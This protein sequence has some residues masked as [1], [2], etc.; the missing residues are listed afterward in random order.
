MAKVFVRR[1]EQD[2]DD[3]VLLHVDAAH[4]VSEVMQDARGLLWTTEGAPALGDMQLCLDSDGSTLRNRAVFT[5]LGIDCTAATLVLKGR[6]SSVAPQTQTPPP[7]P[8][9]SMSPS[10][11]GTTST[12]GIANN[13]D[14]YGGGAGISVAVLASGE[15]TH[16][17][18]SPQGRRAVQTH[19]RSTDSSLISV[20]LPPQQRSGTRRDDG[21]TLLTGD[22]HSPR[23]P[24]RYKR[25]HSASPP[26]MKTTRQEWWGH[27]GGYGFG[28]AHGESAERAAP[29]KR[30]C[31]ETPHA[32]KAEH[33]STSANE[34]VT[35]QG[36]SNTPCRL[37]SPQS[38]TEGS[39]SGKRH[40]RAQEHHLD[41]TLQADPGT[42]R[43]DG[44]RLTTSTPREDPRAGGYGLGP[45]LRAKMTQSNVV[46][47]EV[48]LPAS[49]PPHNSK[50]FVSSVGAL[51]GQPSTTTAE[52]MP[53][54]RPPAPSPDTHAAR[55]APA[56]TPKTASELRRLLLQQVALC[57]GHGS[58][59]EMQYAWRQLCQGRG[60]LRVEDFCG[61]VARE[62]RVNVKVE[63]L[64]E[65]GHDAAR[66][67]FK[68]FC[69][70]CG[71][72][73]GAGEG[74]V[75]MPSEEPR[76]SGIKCHSIAQHT[77]RAPFGIVSDAPPPHRSLRRSQAGGASY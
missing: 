34:V 37:P 59:G 22:V 9:P 43:I 25:V 69:A 53:R 33:L 47:G 8:R 35:R 36:H 60:T 23:D 38:P 73:G 72:G 65:M 28:V 10:P 31:V 3:A 49:P 45:G 5:T 6:A 77:L 74:D 1:E 27:S 52:S 44:R 71:G 75:R 2:N 12:A 4:T 32:S 17:E 64:E 30:G 76:H 62:F 57:G 26:H 40:V 54:K 14:H 16:A 66:V 50:T 13:L 61:A 15:G 63:D 19:T 67:S 51:M 11:R 41:S 24:Q 56:V 29:V 20:G 48:D 70:L 21:L 18:H 42:M 68:D 46:L 39:P 7:L 58:L 55:E